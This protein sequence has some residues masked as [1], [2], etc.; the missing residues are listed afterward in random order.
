MNE[1]FSTIPEDK[2]NKEKTLNSIQGSGRLSIRKGLGRMGKDGRGSLSYNPE[3]P[4]VAAQNANTSGA[5]S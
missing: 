1:Y 4:M 2:I 5:T 3:D